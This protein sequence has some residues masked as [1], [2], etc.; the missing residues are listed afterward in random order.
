[1]LTAP[2]DYAV[3][4]AHYEQLA[5]GACPDAETLLELGS[6]GGNNASHLKH[7]F[8]CTLTDLSPEMLALSE[9]LNPDCEHLVGDMRS[10]RLGR[11]FDVVFVHDAVMYLTSEAD[12]AACAETAFLH[13]RPGGVALFAPDCT[14][15]GYV[16]ST[17]HGGHD[18]E[19]GRSL[20][21][22]EWTHPVEPGSSVGVV[23]FGVLL[24]EADGTTR[25][26]HD[27]HLFGLF[28]ERTWV[29]T[30]EAAGLDVTVMPGDPASEETPQPVFVA[31]RPV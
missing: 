26:V 29:E 28:P 3:E 11:S 2:E 13:L 21:Y 19:T 22:V 14:L 12:L 4:A 8:S 30:L 25:V 16:P 9:T 5:L 18:G 7:R 23:D 15:E 31:V 10:L 6:G 27:R 24:R 1:L 20:R 17:S